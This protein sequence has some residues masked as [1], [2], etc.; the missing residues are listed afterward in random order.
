[1][2]NLGRLV[3]LFLAVTLA[4]CSGLSSQ[5]QPDM[6]ETPTAAA[7]APLP[8]STASAAKVTFDTC[9]VDKMYIPELPLKKDER[10]RWNIIALTPEQDKAGD[11]PLP[12][13]DSS[14]N[15]PSPPATLVSGYTVSY[16][17]AGPKADDMVVI[18]GHSSPWRVLPFNS[19]MNQ[20]KEGDEAPRVRKGEHIYLHT[21]CSG[22]WWLEYVVNTTLT[23]GKP[24]FTSDP[25][26]FGKTKK[27]G[28]LVLITCLQPEEG[29]STQVVVVIG[30][31]G[32]VVRFPG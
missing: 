24:G 29:H 7:S 27:P 4:G 28:R 15:D 17:T 5:P 32:K 31:L 2:N 14:L 11:I 12:P 6:T 26:I 21:I 10:N 22:K 25:R 8:T 1:M 19:L 23:A 13:R 30:Q 20:G 18:I 3:A 16:H 9:A